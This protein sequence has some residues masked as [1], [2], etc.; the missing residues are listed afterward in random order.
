[1]GGNTQ[2]RIVFPEEGEEQVVRYGVAIAEVLTPEQI[3]YLIDEQNLYRESD[4]AG[5]GSGIPAAIK[6][7]FFVIGTGILVAAAWPLLVEV[8]AISVVARMA[9]WLYRKYTEVSNYIEAAEEKLQIVMNRD[10]IRA[11]VWYAGLAHT[12]GMNFSYRYREQVEKIYDFTGDVSRQVFGDANMLAGALGTLRLVIADVTRLQGKPVDI[13]DTIWWT[14]SV[15]VLEDIEN[16][17]DRYSRRPAAF[18]GDFGRK[19]LTPQLLEASKEEEKR[20]TLLTTLGDGIRLADTTTTALDDRFKEY[21]KEV[22]PFLSPENR[23]AV[24]KMRQDQYLNVILPL[25]SLREFADTTMPPVISK[26]QDNQED[27]L[28]NQVKIAGLEDLTDSPSTLSE[29]KQIVQG[30]RFTEILGNIR[31]RDEFTFTALSDAQTRYE[32]ILEQIDIRGRF[33]EEEE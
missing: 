12:A 20:R 31:G 13:G 5:S 2:I 11:A 32:R 17:A 21:L 1:M 23:R 14:K 29:P 15:K 33:V 28:L 24:D 19:Y 4:T 7:T 10:E 3:A 8:G 26:V 27:I 6:Y 25:R 16:N 9:T 30:N 22:D 18:W